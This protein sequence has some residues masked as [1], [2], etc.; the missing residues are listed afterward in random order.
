MNRPVVYC[1]TC[2][3]ANPPGAATCFSCGNPPLST[4]PGTSPSGGVLL[5]QRYRLLAQI[6]TGGF[7]A[8]YQAEDTELGNRKVAIKE[9]SQHG[10]T[11]EEAQEAIQNFRQEALLLAELTHPNLPRIYEQFSEGG[12][13]YLVMDF[14]QGESL[15]AHLSR[16]PGGRLPVQEVLKLAVQLC[17]VF[18]YLHTRQ[19][20]IIFRDLKPAN[21]MLTP[22][23]QLYLIDFGIARHFKPG[24]T[25][26][27]TAFGSAG[28]AA[29]EQYGKAQTTTRSDIYSLGATLHQV[30]SGSDPS[31]SPFLFAPLHLAEPEGLEALVMQMLEA[32]PANRPASMALIGHDLEHMAQELTTGR[33]TQHAQALHSQARN[34]LHPLLVYRGHSDGVTTLSWSPR[35]RY[36]AS[37][38]LDHTIQIWE[39]ATGKQ[40]QMFAYPGHVYG[41]AWSPKGKELAW[42]G[43]GKAVDLWNGHT[44]HFSQLTHRHLGFLRR[45]CALAWS[46]DGACLAAADGHGQT[47]EVWE[48]KT[49]N[50]LLTYTGQR[51][52]LGSY[53]V[54]AVTWSPNG[55]W[56]ASVSTNAMTQ[57]WEVATGQ[58]LCTYSQGQDGVASGIAWSPDGKW[59][60]TPGQHATI[61]IWGAATGRQHL[62]LGGHSGVVNAVAWSPDGNLLASGSSVQTVRIWSISAAKAH[63]L[64]VYHLPCEV[65]ALIWSPD[66]TRLAAAGDNQIVYIWQVV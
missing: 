18:D 34:P 53:E 33:K 27:T 32:D 61:H 35:G 42:V 1:A 46:P 12:H 8:V 50:H 23:G 3:A 45:F 47:V 26:D 65:R 7:G 2:G 58:L 20:P 29:P 15:E 25:R 62:L 41:L 28:Y 43:D 5:K 39:S 16:A 56:M 64:R 30:L 57:V 66:S 37:G 4:P 6:G 17:A 9:M 44:G 11:P 63:E 48:V 59:I 38:G 21:I 19:P 31:N 60:A 24:Q 14:I 52:F 49:G 54:C 55:A 13:W 22:A 40:T 36:L 10:L 51:G